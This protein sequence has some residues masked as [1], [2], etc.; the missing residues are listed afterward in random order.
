MKK[1]I[2][3][4]GIIAIQISFAQ[5]ANNFMPVTYP[6]SPDVTKMQ[7]YGQIPV[8]QYSGT[9]NVS[10]PIYTIKEGDFEFPITLDYNTRGIKVRE[11]A[12]R[13]GLGWSLGFPGLISRNINGQ[14]DFIGGYGQLNGKYFNSRAKNGSLIPDFTGYV[15][16]INFLKLGLET[17]IMPGNYK[18]EDYVSGFNVRDNTDFQPDDYYY[19]LPKYSGK[20]I[21]KRDRTSVLEK[22]QD[23]LKIEI[24]DS[25]NSVGQGTMKKL[26][27]VDPSGTTYTFDDFETYLSQ[28]HIGSTAINIS[29]N[30]AWYVTKIKTK[31][32]KEIKFTYDMLETIPSYNLYEIYGIPM[33]FFNDGNGGTSPVGS[34]PY[35][36]SKQYEGWREFKSKLIKKIEFSTGSVEF[37]YTTRQDLYGDKR[38][39]SI[40][41]KDKNGRFVKKI[42]LNHDYFEKNFNSLLTELGDWQQSNATSGF[43][44]RQDVLNK[45]LK[46]SSL[47]YLNS[48]EQI[49]NKEIYEYY[50]QYIPAKNS[51]AIDYWGY[52]NGESQNQHLF[53]NFSITVPE[54]FGDFFYIYK[55]GNEHTLTIPGV[56]RQ[57]SP[58]FTNS[59][60]L[61]KIVYPTKGFT[62]FEYENNTYDPTKSFQSDPNASRY[63]L[64]RNT[65]LNGDKFNLAGGLR[66]KSLTNNDNA[67]G[68]YRKNYV[69][70]NTKD[71]NNDGISENYSN[72]YLLERPNLFTLR[73]KIGPVPLSAPSGPGPIS[74]PIDGPVDINTDIAYIL[75]KNMPTYDNDFIGYETVDEIVDNAAN[76][77][78]IK[79]TYTYDVSP[80]QTYNTLFDLMKGF[81]APTPDFSE[82]QNLYIKS[83]VRFN[84]FAL[85]FEFKTFASDNGRE[86]MRDYAFDYKPDFFKNDKGIKN[87]LLKSMNQYSFNNNSFVLISSEDYEYGLNYLPPQYWGVFYDHTYFHNLGAEFKFWT[88]QQMAYNYFQW[89]LT[90]GYGPGYYN[91]PYKALVPIY[92]P[93]VTSI[94][95]REY[96]NGN[97]ITTKTDNEYPMAMQGQYS[98]NWGNLL[99][100]KITF[101]DNTIKESTYKYA[102]DKNNQKL[103]SANMINIPLETIITNKQ[104]VSDTGK[105]ISKTE[106]KYNNPA[107][108]FPTSL[109]RYNTLAGSM[110]TEVT[111]DKYDLNGNI[112]QYTAKNGISTTIIWG[113]NHTQPI[114][115]IEGAKLSDIPQ[116]LIDNIVNASVNDGQLSTE[117][118]EQ[119]LISALDVFRNNA[120]LSAYQIS[121]YSYDPLIGVKSITP[122]SG[123]REFYIYD[124]ANRLKEVRENSPTGKILKEYKYNYKN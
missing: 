75:L 103:L 8:S 81:E 33:N 113:Y 85:D 60:L 64:Y 88:N 97:V 24:L 58:V 25:V 5:S 67:G 101:P 100:Q 89:A 29:A 9:A 47:E 39:A 124:T 32:G 74:S 53:M 91:V 76:N 15:S 117:A 82:S 18:L 41:L 84:A 1:T 43:G 78:K 108:I 109:L 40:S 119:S 118:S 49:I 102:F 55:N 36:Q 16:P 34:Y 73:P 80:T 23:K 62:E 46:L 50:D 112:Q 69:Y 38:I 12:T 114:A 63:S 4:I 65:N 3:A 93:G 96:F 45:R 44:N 2:T 14:D 48:E 72:G 105:I 122:P 92:N 98:P 6:T 121:T 61:K 26:K 71:L 51:T 21:F 17:K 30:N 120:A 35:M 86:Y 28:E 115:K 13:V 77:A 19:K 95:K 110:E 42:K 31:E 90:N 116:A 37:E 56:N 57:V 10:V 79:T 99:S 11:E 83:L 54:V 94:T 70:H 123:I 7:T 106:T 111:L 20:F 52:F 22:V 27:V 104:N 59:M 66:I 107:D 87:G 68:M